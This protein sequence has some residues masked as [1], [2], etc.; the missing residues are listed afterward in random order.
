MGVVRKIA[1]M[2][3][4]AA[5]EWVGAPSGRQAEGKPASERERLREP[6]GRVHPRKGDV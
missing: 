2:A 6:K 1:A 4:K 3:L 5:A